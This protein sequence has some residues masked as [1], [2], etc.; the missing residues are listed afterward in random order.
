[1]RFFRQI[2]P[3]VLA[4][5]I[6][7]GCRSS[8][9]LKKHREPQARETAKLVS[10]LLEAPPVREMTAS[11]SLNIAGNKV[12]GQLRMRRGKS[13]QISVSML[14][15]VE[16]ARIEF[17]PEMV[18]ATDRIHNVY[19]VFHYADIPYRNEL[20][21]DFEVVQ[22][23]LWNRLFSPGTAD[24]ADAASKFVI[25]GSDDRGAVSIRDMECGYLFVSD[26]RDRL[27]AV[28]KTAGSFSFRI[29]YSDFTALSGGWK[30]PLEWTAQI[31]TSGL[32]LGFSAKL[33]SVSADKKNWPDRTQVSSRMKLVSL[34]E[35][36]DNLDL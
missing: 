22:A 12:N 32:Q 25:E 3:I 7:G 6:L 2:L 34:Q 11:L 20:G 29:G 31:N 14:G 28:S 27:D 8:S 1:M 33:S 9:S 13:I 18:V 35:M 30:Y 5:F 19:S 36:L 4:A 24:V 15:L 21:L 23:F 17:L 10:T 26:G 16:V